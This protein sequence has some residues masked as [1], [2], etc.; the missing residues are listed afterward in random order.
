V[1]PYLIAAI[2]F[3]SLAG[4]LL[5]LGL[6]YTISHNRGAGNVY[7]CSVNPFNENGQSNAINTYFEPFYEQAT[8]FGILVAVVGVAI[9]MVHLTSKKPIENK[10]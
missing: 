10:R 5:S 4:I 3:F 8:L 6:P 1:K 2:A 7:C 9:L